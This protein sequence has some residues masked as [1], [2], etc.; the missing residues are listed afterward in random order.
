MRLG[1]WF[2]AL[3]FD[4]VTKQ[5]LGQTLQRAWSHGNEDAALLLAELLLEGSVLPKDVQEAKRILIKLAAEG[6]SS[7]LLTLVEIERHSSNVKGNNAFSW[8]R[9][10]KR[11]E[12]SFQI[13]STCS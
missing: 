4:G 7:A 13:V 11:Q 10:A 2:V 9:G 1:A 5:N 6:N 12:N 8:R 3:R